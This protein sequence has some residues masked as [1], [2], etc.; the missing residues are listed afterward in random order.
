MKRYPTEWKKTYADHISDK[1]L[2]FKIYKEL[3]QLNNKKTQ[4]I[5]LKNGLKT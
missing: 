3:K 4:T 2:V 5:Q 1:E